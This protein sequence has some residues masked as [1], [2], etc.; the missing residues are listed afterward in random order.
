MLAVQGP[1]EPLTVGSPLPGAFNVANALP[2]PWLLRRRSASTRRRGRGRAGRPR[3]SRAGWSAVDA[4]QDVP[5]VVVDYA[6]KPDAV[7]AALHALRP[8]DR[9]AGWSSSLGRGGDRDPGKRPV[10]GRSRRGA[11]TSLVVTDDNP[12]SEDP[13]A[14][15]AAMLAG[16]RAAARA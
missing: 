4:G 5:A 6:H 16:A 7:E 12:R 11:P 1:N 13:A 10:M 8:L 15:R 2:R 3:A 14:I 9:R